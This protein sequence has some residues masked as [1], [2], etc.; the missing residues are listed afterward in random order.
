MILQEAVQAV[1]DRVEKDT[2]VKDYFHSFDT[3]VV[4][5]TIDAPS[6]LWTLREV[7]FRAFTTAQVLGVSNDI[8]VIIGITVTTGSDDES[9]SLAEMLQALEIIDNALEKDDI[10]YGNRLSNLLLKFD[11]FETVKEGDRNLFKAEGTI[12]LT[13][14]PYAGG[15]V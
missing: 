11:S 3:A 9:V 13:V 5:E 6:I 2:N 4:T 12:T 1:I 7:D 10:T 14:Q 15:S 8:Q